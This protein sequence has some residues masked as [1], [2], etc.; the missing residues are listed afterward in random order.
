MDISGLPAQPLESS[1][2]FVEELR[3]PMWS[4]HGWVRRPARPEEADLGQGVSLVVEFADPG[5]CLATALADWGEFLKAGGVSA[6]GSYSLRLRL[7]PG[8]GEEAFELTVE[9]GGAVLAGGDLEGLRRGIFFV[10]DAMLTAGGP[11]LPLGRH[12]RRP[13]VR[14]RFSRCFFGPIKRPPKLRDELLDEVD[15]YPEHYLNR[16]AHDGVNALWLTVEFRDLCRTS[17]TPEYGPQADRRFAK[18]QRTVDAC[19]RYGIRTYLFCIEPRAWEADEPAVQRHPELG[20]VLVGGGRRLF[21]PSSETARQYLRECTELIFRRVPGLGGIINISHGERPTTCLSGLAPTGVGRVSCPVCA[22][23]QPWEI[24]YD[25]L[26]ALEAGM[27]AV[28]PGAELISWLYMPQERGPFQ[29]DLADWVYDIPF[30]TPPR[31][32]LQFNFETG[33][34]RE[35]FGRT[36]VGGDY[37]LSEPGPSG[38]FARIAEAARRG[39]TLLGAKIQNGCSHEVA[40]APYVPVPSLLHRKYAAMRELG[41]SHVMLCWY[42]GNYPGLMNRAGCRLCCEPFP[43]SED[44]FLRE[45]AARDWGGHAEAVAGAWK[46]FAEGYRNFPL[47]NYFQYYGPMHDG[48]VWPLHLKPVDAFLA[49]TWLLGNTQTREP[50]PPS[51]DRIGE[52]LGPY[53]LDE[54]IALCRRLSETWDRGL[55]LLAGI[56][57]R[58]RQQ[59][60]DLGVAEALGCQFRSGL[61]I[62]QFYEHRERL[63]R[64]DGELERLTLLGE[65]YRLV[66]AEQADD[67][68]LAVL[69]EADSRLGF[70]SEAEGYKY[71]PAK[72]RWRREQLARLL[73]ED[74][75]EIEATIRRGEPLFPAYTGLEP[76]GPTACCPFRPAAAVAFA[77]G[78]P[79]DLPWQESRSA[80][81]SRAISWACCRDGEALY[82]FARTT[83]PL[84]ENAETGDFAIDYRGSRPGVV[85]RLEE[86]RLWPSRFFA[87]AWA[88]GRSTSEE[89]A[90]RVHS[91]DDSRL[92][93]LRIPFATLRR[94]PADP[95]PLRIDV[96]GLQPGRPPCHWV[97]PTPFPYRLR[98]GNENPADLGW[99]RFEGE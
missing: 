17:L 57:P 84:P 66:Q 21:C 13:F 54:G 83:E 9:A 3:Q 75:P 80:D 94:D 58:N 40:T 91:F 97:H 70:H 23:K 44:E 24:L 86:R 32:V 35:D 18:L 37:W 96:A 78:A 1:W 51:G 27:H 2:G 15:Y 67:E 30:H 61:R 31:V 38:R 33:V 72:L 90:A 81:G 65:M 71:F 25:S 62:L 34:C 14:R 6:S 36:I 48:P 68:R 49:P 5:G 10:E 60:L 47:T 56:V 19:L 87:A 74:F 42:F 85:L 64:S 63:F 99:L 89:F 43:E 55:D 39:Y 11:F 7:E 98:F 50:W 59:A 28:A 4:E 73:A 69:A 77:Q 12:G 26:A 52:A 92:V 79:G 82:L 8:V 46:L 41:V 22:A 16:L 45:L 95:W 29:T 88:G 53:S 93:V 20:R 76:A